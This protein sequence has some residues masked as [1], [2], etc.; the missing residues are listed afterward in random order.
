MGAC[1]CGLKPVIVKLITGMGINLFTKKPKRPTALR[2]GKL[3]EKALWIDG[4]V[5]YRFKNLADMPYLR[6]LRMLQF[7]TEVQMRIDSETLS[8]SLD[9]MEAALEAGKGTEIA[10]LIAVLKEKT[11]L[12]ISTDAI[13]RLLSCVF[14]TDDEYLDDYDFDVG[15]K[16]IELFKKKVNILEMLSHESAKKFIPQIDL[17]EGDLVAY[18]MHE[19]EISKILSQLLISKTANLTDK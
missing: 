1:G 7:S 14:F 3:V 18:S 2:Q 9:A 6:Y 11:R 12:L 16:K 15:D 4:E 8:E 5:Y 10:K 13:Y 17:S 19:K